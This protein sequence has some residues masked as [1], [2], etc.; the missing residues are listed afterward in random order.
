M[1]KPDGDRPQPESPLVR[2]PTLPP[3]FPDIPQNSSSELRPPHDPRATPDKVA[4]TTPAPAQPETHAKP[5][6]APERPCARV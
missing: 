5:R 4:G 1:P 2:P 6:P 3:D